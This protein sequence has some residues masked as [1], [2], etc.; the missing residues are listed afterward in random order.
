MSTSTRKPRGKRGPYKKTKVTVKTEDISDFDPSEFDDDELDAYE[1]DDYTDDDD[2]EER[3]GIALRLQRVGIEDALPAS[4]IRNVRIDE[5]YRALCEDEIELD[6]AY[7]RDVVWNLPKRTGLIDSI[8]RNFY[9]PPVVFA[10]HTI[11]LPSGEVKERR[12][13]VDGKQR[14]TSI[15]NFIDGKIPYKHPG[16]RR[17]LFYTITS[18]PSKD[19]DAKLLKAKGKGK[20]KAKVEESAGNA[21]GSGTNI[22]GAG[23]STHANETTTTTGRGRG[24]GRVKKERGMARHGAEFVKRYELNKTLRDVFNAKE[25]TV[26]EYRNLTDPLERDLFRRVQLGMSLNSAEKLQAISSSW[27]DWITALD[28]RHLSNP[29][30]LG[31]LITI[32]SS[33]SRSFLNLTQLIAACETYR[34]KWRNI[35]I[36]PAPGTVVASPGAAPTYAGL[37]KFLSNS[38]DPTDELKEEIE[39]VLRAMTEIAADEQKKGWAK[40]FA[41][42]GGKVQSY[43]T[44]PDTPQTRAGMRVAP[45][46]FLFMGLLLFVLPK[47]FVQAQLD[48]GFNPTPLTYPVTALTYASPEEALSASASTFVHP[49]IGSSSNPAANGGSGPVEARDIQAALLLELREWGRARFLDLRTNSTVCRGMWDQVKMYEERWGARG[50]GGVKVKKEE[51]AEEEEDELAL[52]STGEGMDVDEPVVS[53]VEVK[54]KSAGKKVNGAAASASPAVALGASFSVGALP[55]NALAPVAFPSTAISNTAISRTT[56]PLATAM[57]LPGSVRAPL[58]ASPAQ[59]VRVS[60]T[61]YPLATASQPSLGSI[62]TQGVGGSGSAL[63]RHGVSW[64]LVG[65]GASGAS[66]SGSGTSSGM[67]GDAVDEEVERLDRQLEEARRQQ[68]E[69]LKQKEEMEEKEKKRKE[70]A[71]EMVRQQLESWKRQ[72]EA[73]KKRKENER[74]MYEQEQRLR[75]R[76]VE[77]TAQEQKVREER[78]RKAREEEENA[79]KQGRNDVVDGDVGMEQAMGDIIDIDALCGVEGDGENTRPQEL[80]PNTPYHF[81]DPSMT[82]VYGTDGSS[83]KKGLE[84]A[85]AKDATVGVKRKQREDDEQRDEVQESGPSDKPVKVTYER[86]TA[87]ARGDEGSGAAVPDRESSPEVVQMIPIPPGVKIG[88]PKKGAKKKRV[89]ASTTNEGASTSTTAPTAKD[90]DPLFTPPA[91][92]VSLSTPPDSLFTPKSSTSSRTVSSQMEQT[93]VSP[94]DTVVVSRPSKKQKVANGSKSKKK[95]DG[96]DDEVVEFLLE[97]QE[98]ELPMPRR[99][100]S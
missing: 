32:E 62:S 30:G 17:S 79:K 87:S 23:T 76:E 7:Q 42:M 41:R 71:A 88:K 96:S 39:E 46:E 90:T 67:N 61:T 25:M 12:V 1:E 9:I 92:S 45:V 55:F 19:E 13:C 74:L 91:T 83:K 44:E 11:T 18:P 48:K 33:R 50:R 8:F 77:R 75:M 52:R 89:A 85:R 80:V 14:L 73:T 38:E 54:T 84:K 6:P 26:V 5:L 16:L 86:K 78:E 100:R 59:P 60:S 43:E 49:V 24:K 53:A 20:A 99:T 4:T 3:E 35:T 57:P 40:C 34:V 63:Y 47:K 97:G 15:K 82:A 95:N 58:S 36:D 64:T 31:S 69:L 94:M 68:Q 66:G 10:V 70:E 72:T 27:A 28:T 22:N 21:T 2:E 37:A 65:G 98:L 29:A 56:Y 51:E 81:P 93:R